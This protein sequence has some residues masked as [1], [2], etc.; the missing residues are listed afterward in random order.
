MN[1]SIFMIADTNSKITCHSQNV[2]RM[3]NKKSIQNQKDL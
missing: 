2:K 1:F 3:E